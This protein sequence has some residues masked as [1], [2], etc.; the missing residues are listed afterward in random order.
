MFSDVSIN[1][2]SFKSGETMVITAKMDNWPLVKRMRQEDFIYSLGVTFD[3]NTTIEPGRASFDEATG[4]C[5][6]LRHSTHRQRID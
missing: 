6:L 2:K 1:K 3:G 4:T 5:D